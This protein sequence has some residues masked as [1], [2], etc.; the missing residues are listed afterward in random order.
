MTFGKD[1]IRRFWYGFWKLRMSIN[2]FLI[3][4]V[5]SWQG[6]QGPQGITLSDKIANFPGTNQSKC[7]FCKLY[8]V[9]QKYSK[10]FS[11]SSFP[12]IS[13]G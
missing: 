11:I 13:S 2:L 7:E 1:W 5:W 10:G 9:D 4:A 8:G 12:S 3:F 6:W